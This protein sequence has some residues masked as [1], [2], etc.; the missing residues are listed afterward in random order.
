MPKVARFGYTSLLLV[1]GSIED[2]QFELLTTGDVHGV[3]AFV[4][5]DGEMVIPFCSVIKA[6]REKDGEK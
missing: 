5:L 3:W 4:S 6:S 2:G 1:D